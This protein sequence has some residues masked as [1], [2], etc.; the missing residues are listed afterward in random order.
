MNPHWALMAYRFWI[1]LVLTMTALSV[2]KHPDFNWDNA[3]RDILFAT[4]LIC[5]PGGVYWAI[6]GRRPW[7]QGR[8]PDSSL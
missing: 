5:L 2:H 3:G 1:V 4:L 7:L 6:T 8:V